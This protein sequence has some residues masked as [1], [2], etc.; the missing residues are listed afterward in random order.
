M[1]YRDYGGHPDLISEYAAEL[2]RA[3]C[4]IL[5]VGGGAAI[6]AAQRATKTIP[7]VGVTDDMVGE[8]FVDSFV[9]PGGNTTGV[10]IF[11]TELDGKRQEAMRWA[12]SRVSSSR[13]NRRR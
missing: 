2:V 10:S 3:Q 12:S 13:R 9:R 7:I 11:A 5:A 4:D 1:E 8:G 6:R